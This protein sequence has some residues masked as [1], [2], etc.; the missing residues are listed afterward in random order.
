MKVSFSKWLAI[1]AVL[2]LCLGSMLCFQMGVAADTLVLYESSDV[3]TVDGNNYFATDADYQDPDGHE[4][5]Y[6][7]GA[8]AF[9]T[10]LRSALAAYGANA[11]Y[12]IDMTISSSDASNGFVPQICDGTSKLYPYINRLPTPPCSCTTATGWRRR[13]ISRP[14]PSLTSS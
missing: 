13:L 8:A 4:Y 1:L 7:L 3:F 5:C 12:T 14:S 2:S 11:T 10:A 6:D 9:N